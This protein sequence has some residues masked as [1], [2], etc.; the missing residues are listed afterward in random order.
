MAD[1]FQV[2]LFGDETGDFREPFQKLCEYQDGVVFR[3]FLDRLK[4][5]LRDEIRQQPRQV[6][7]QIP[8]FNDIHE[9][10]NRYIE[11]GSRTPI[12]E[13]TFACICQLASVICFLE[14]SESEY[15]VPSDTVLVGMC[16]GLLAS[17]AVS[18]SNSLLELVSI[19]LK[20]VRVAFRIG[21]K[22]DGASRR[23]SVDNVEASQSWSRLVLGGQT[24]TIAPKVAQFNDTKGLPRANQ[25]YISSTSKDVVTISGP[26]ETLRALFQ[27]SEFFRGRK[28]VALDIFGPF[29]AS[30]LYNDADIEEVLQPIT[31]S[32]NK[33]ARPSIR[34]ISGATEKISLDV[35]MDKVMAEI[36]K[37]ILIRPLGFD[38]VLA[39]VASEVRKSGKTTCKVSS[40]GPSKALT[41]VVSAVKAGKTEVVVGE[42]LGAIAPEEN[43]KGTVTKIAVVGMSSRLPNAPDLDGLWS[44]LEQ[45]LDVHRRVPPDRFDIDAHYDPTGKKKNTSITPFGCFIE[46]PGLFD[47]RFFNMSP[48]EAYQTDPMGRLALVTAYEALEM[49]GFVP[50][51][52][53]STMLDR[54]GTFY[55]QTSDDWRQVNAAQKVDTYYIPGTIRAFASGRINY[56]FKFSGPSYNVDTACSSSF[57]ALQ[58]ACS[59]LLS[60]ECDT[61]VAGGLNV[62]T[63]PDLFAGLSRAQ[64]LSKT[65]SCKTFD[66][67]ADGFCRGDG[68]ATVILKRL[69]D[70][71]ADNDPILGVV[72]GATTNH[73]AEAVSITQPH[74]ETQ[75]TLYRRILKKTGV[76]FEEVS[77][78]EMHGTGTQAGDGAEMKSI[79]SVFAPAVDGKQ[80]ARSPGQP[81]YIGALKSNIGH[82]EASA[83]VASLVKVLLMM[84]RNAIPPHVGIK[85]KMNRGFPKDMKERGIH[86]AFKK[87]PWLAPPGGKRR[88]YLNNFSAAG[89]NTGLLV[90]DG[91]IS[92]AAGANSDP[93]TAFVVAVTARSAWSLEE[94]VKKLISYLDKHPNTSLPN[95]SYTTT[96]RKLQHPFRISV[97]VSDISEVKNALITAQKVSVKAV[98]AKAP[99]VSFAFTGQ[100]SHYLALGKELYESSSRFRTDILDFDRIGQNQ[101]FPTFLPLVDGSVKD[102]D[103]L[104]PVVLQVGQSCIQMALTRLWKSWGITPSAVV[105]HSLGEYAALNAAGVL[106]ASDTIYL[107]GRRA[108]LLENKC[109]AGTH[110]MLAVATTVSSIRE[111]LVGENIEVACVNGPRESVISGLAEQ[112]ISYS[113][114]LKGAGIRC[115]LL[116]T[117]YAFH[118]TQVSTILES[119]TEQASSINFRRPAV[120]VIS[121]LLRKVV[122]DSNVFGAEYL[123]RHA[124]EQVDF[125][126]GI[127]QAAAEKVIDLNTIWVEIGPSP[128]CSAFLKSTLGAEAITTASLRKKEDPWK[129]TANSLALLQRKGANIEWD[130]VHRE[131]ESS[132]RVL[133]LPMYAFENKN[134]W[135]EYTNNWCLNKG[136]LL[137]PPSEAYKR[138]SDR[139]STSSIQKVTKED[140]GK[141]VTIVAESDLSDP[142]L[143]AA[144]TGHLVNGSALC[145]SAVYADMAQTLAGYLHRKVNN[146]EDNEIGLDVRHLEIMKPLIAKG[147]GSKEP[148]MVRITATAER[149]L[150]NVQIKYSSISPDGKET[151][152]HATCVVE[153]A[154]KKTWVKEW[155]RMAY[156]FRSR[157]DTLAQGA[158]KKYKSVDRSQAYGLFSSLVDYDKHYHGMK[159]VII[160]GKNFEATSVVEFQASQH[161][162]NFELAPH[163]IDN[164][165]HISGFVLNGNSEAVDLKKTV[166][167]S[168]GWESLQ[169]AQPLSASKQYRNY[170]K[171][172]EGLKG[173]MAGDVYVF[174]GEE[175]VAL[176]GGVKFQAIPRVVLNKL[177]PPIN[178][179][180][181]VPSV[182]RNK[183]AKKETAPA[184]PKPIL[185]KASVAIPSEPTYSAPT[186]TAANPKSDAFV[187]IIAE[188]LGMDTS[189][190]PDSS[191]F[192]DIGV[193]SLMSLTITGR[194]REELDL[195]VPTSLFTDL[196]SIGEVKA[197]LFGHSASA[198]VSHP[199]EAVAQAPPA[200]EIIPSTEISNGPSSAATNQNTEAFI[201]IIAEEL[202]METSELPDSALFADIGVDSLMS[203]TITG[204]IREELD[205]DVPT[206]LFTDHDSI[207]E[208]KAALFGLN[209]S[210]NDSIE[211]AVPDT[212]SDS[213]HESTVSDGPSSDFTNSVMA[214]MSPDKTI[215]EILGIISEELGI[216]EAELIEIADFADMGVDSLMS[217]TITG[218][219]REELELDVPTSFFTDH[220][221]IS[222]AKTAVLAILGL[223]SSSSRS[224][225]P[226]SSTEDA[227]A[228]DKSMAIISEET[229]TNISLQMG[230]SRKVDAQATSILLQGN[231]KTAT[232]TLF[233]FPDGSGSA[234]SYSAFPNISPE[235]C[236]YGL[237]CPYMKNPKDFTNGIDGVAAQYIAEVKRRQPSGP[238]HLGGWS[239]GGVIAYDAAQQ[240]LEM[241]EEVERLILIDSPCP[242]NIE[243]L[244]TSLLNFIDSTGI[245]GTGKAPEWLIPHFE[246]TVANLT[247]Y[248]PYPMDEHLAPKTS[249]IWARNGLSVSGKGSYPRS[250]SEPKS[251]RFLLDKRPENC[252]PY[253]WDML[254]GRQNIVRIDMV[255]GD[256]F[257]MIRS[258]GSQVLAPLLRQSLG[259]IG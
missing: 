51:R 254:L 160:N 213:M 74:P 105:G 59:A 124:R 7:E 211:I 168:H 73:S 93:R 16:T 2:H 53:P 118:S 181:T 66:D 76:N 210:G 230:T 239:A 31:E 224:D 46:D 92:A 19:A 251:V 159:E 96:A 48:R 113:K 30:H 23:L 121:P 228:N 190:L 126:G 99:N 129:T 248:M 157:I 199:V 241:G 170:V 84:Q 226:D 28:S 145:P 150:K 79:S 196:A 18:A 94:N 133:Q 37:D 75:E 11:S 154:D 257:S 55:G 242:I 109:V 209:S 161:D 131:Y 185:K 40:V 15:F 141:T 218:R 89:G 184:V 27:E 151:D 253:R 128:V 162:G 127:Q 32:G 167:I 156:L 214:G 153:F 12:L 135:I 67:A 77:Y 232:K 217:L 4:D 245:L 258:P 244:P 166:Y 222:K 54:I 243:P 56:H 171:M 42:Q 203:L 72:L 198:S 20:V 33:V 136:E 70:A 123:A 256:H 47:P 164:I 247:A 68:V 189:E 63:T 216:D 149:P 174:Q 101:G 240:L 52:T 148:Q 108:Q 137:V 192:A 117:A 58:L 140:L 111:I 259:I 78:V 38:R 134:Y 97:A 1:K 138:P 3:H 90:E 29:H 175:M 146:K 208:A 193:D 82:G 229:N 204:R 112:M 130:E 25:A 104:S 169:I 143:N 191:L 39:A 132:L 206:S 147:K 88:A 86:I 246:A 24:D 65:G 10:V 44:V 202:G 152:L 91:P 144:V 26:P 172:H 98:S 110:A 8:S 14:S 119:F 35:G 5:V 71:V 115:T 80:K 200:T 142:G 62:M 236:V 13:T 180:G 215:E 195:E 219:L 21:V 187:G 165:A 158:N 225:T 87:T 6:Q 252:G 249:L 107:V 36:V 155:S 17:A 234:T 231:P 227:N 57:S 103:L 255:D 173:T 179:A 22:V 49:S 183:V 194:I 177:L 64:F 100:G 102:L 223:E 43:R 238:Y 45:G 125:L 197:A 139:L 116:S 250:P 60:K 235:V 120:P 95:L 81:L 188:E 83:G 233:L 205:I 207:G 237:N 176:V 220:P 212:A 50:N 34:I 201:G 106:S 69:E 85:G 186:I 41:S 122:T 178:G 61:A 114:T 9:L 221:T 163:W 182:A